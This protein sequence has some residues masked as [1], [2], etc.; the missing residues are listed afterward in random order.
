MSKEKFA[1]IFIVLLILVWVGQV[2][3]LLFF[4]DELSQLHVRHYQSY[5]YFINPAAT[6]GLILWLWWKMRL[7]NTGVVFLG[8]ATIL[9]ITLIYMLVTMPK[10]E[11]KPTIVCDKNNE[12]CRL[13][14]VYGK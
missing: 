13:H 3:A 6:G 12:N 14:P 11:Q 9:V 4:T 5:D 1:L 2:A 7:K 10:S 8:F